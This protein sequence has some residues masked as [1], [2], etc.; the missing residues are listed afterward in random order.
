MQHSDHRRNN[1]LVI[2]GTRGTGK[3]VVEQLIE[4]GCSCTVLAR[5]IAKAKGLFGD[6]VDI[7]YGDVTCPESLQTVLNSTFAAII[8]TVDITDGLG[9][10]GFAAKC[11]VIQ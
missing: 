9:G 8:Y 11:L 5:N 3:T 1:I 10:R 2:G 6:T 4:R 7:V